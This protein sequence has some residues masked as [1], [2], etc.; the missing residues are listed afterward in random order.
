MRITKAGLLLKQD[1]KVNS[2]LLIHMSF[3]CVFWCWAGEQSVCPSQII[4]LRK[5]ERPQRGLCSSDSESY[6]I[7]VC[8]YLL[9]GHALCLAQCGTQQSLEVQVEAHGRLAVQVS[10]STHP[11]HLHQQVLEA[12]PGVEVPGRPADTQSRTGVGHRLR[13]RCRRGRS[14]CSYL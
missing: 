1:F 10:G 4:S 12:R 6:S 13:A 14:G 2:C 11:W 5:P 7:V 9:S 3:I 8:L